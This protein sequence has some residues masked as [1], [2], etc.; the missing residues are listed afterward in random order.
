MTHTKNFLMPLLLG[1]G[2][3]MVIFLV[4]LLVT[5]PKNKLGLFADGVRANH[6][7]VR[8]DDQEEPQ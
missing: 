5:H 3:L 6:P 7:A 8:R 2:G 1:L 4:V